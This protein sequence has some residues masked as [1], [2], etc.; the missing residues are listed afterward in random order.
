VSSQSEVPVLTGERLLRV[1]VGTAPMPVFPAIAI[2]L[3]GL[4]L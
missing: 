4:A 1:I 2:V 3:S